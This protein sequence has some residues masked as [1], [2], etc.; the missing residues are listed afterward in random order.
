MQNAFF[1]AGEI[2][3][4]YD[5]DKLFLAMGFGAEI[6]PLGNVSHEFFLNGNPENP[7]CQGVQGILDAYHQ[8]L[9]TG[10]L[11]TTH[12]TGRVLVIFAV[13]T[14]LMRM[15]DC[16]ITVTL[17]EPT[18]FAPVINHVARFAAK[19]QDGKNYFVLLIITNGDI[20]GKSLLVIEYSPFEQHRLANQM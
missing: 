10:R 13:I 1:V 19:R 5:S 8:T 15:T 17:S 7:F 3:Q 4:D 20:C 12:A 6:P 9:E 2:I 14:L 16:Y 11:A 18:Y